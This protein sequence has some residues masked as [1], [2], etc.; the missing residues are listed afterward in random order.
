VGF[1]IMLAIIIVQYNFLKRRFSQLSKKHAA[2]R[3]IVKRFLGSEEDLKREN[4]KHRS[5]PAPYRRL[6]VCMGVRVRACAYVPVCVRVRVRACAYA[7]ARACVRMYTRV[8]V[9]ACACAC[10]CVCMC[11]HDF[12]GTRY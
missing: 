6:R 4:A 9:H 10:M 1:A 11:V 3:R 5:P 2:I 7:C 8:H 12:H